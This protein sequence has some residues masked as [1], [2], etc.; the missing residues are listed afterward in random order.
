MKQ[1]NELLTE[2]ISLKDKWHEFERKMSGQ[3]QGPNIFYQ[4]TVRLDYKT[5]SKSVW[6]TF[7]YI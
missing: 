1:Q 6:G 4:S 7:V 2:N 3:G 5:P